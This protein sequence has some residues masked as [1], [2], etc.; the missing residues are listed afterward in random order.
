M[1]INLFCYR[2]YFLITGN[3]TGLVL[4]LL[5]MTTDYFYRSHVENLASKALTALYC[6]SIVHYSGV[7]YIIQ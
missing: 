6:V 3:A 5:Y 7:H 1:K 4:H 2:Q